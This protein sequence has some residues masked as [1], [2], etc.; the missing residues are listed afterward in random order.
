[1]KK[2]ITRRPPLMVVGMKIVS[3]PMAEDISELWTKFIARM[4]ELESVAVPECSLGICTP[5][6]DGKIEYMAACVVKDDSTI[7]A[8]ME[9]KLLPEQD[10][11]VFTH[12]GS[13]ENLADTYDYIYNQ[14]L[15]DSDYEIASEPEIEWYD[16]RF[17][18]DDP[19]SQ[20]DIH[21][22]IKPIDIDEK[23]KEIFPS[24]GEEK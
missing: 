10:V 6:D 16:S 9:V 17:K 11:A 7:P 2:L 19:K 12:V 15:P 4:D 21:I 23:L 8:G 1:M 14:W 5:L 18:Y 22:P 24:S 3:E 20:M 13:L